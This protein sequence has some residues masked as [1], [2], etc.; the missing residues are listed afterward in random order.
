MKEKLKSYLFH[1][2]IYLKSGKVGGSSCRIVIRVHR[3]RSK[4]FCFFHL[5]H[6]DDISDEGILNLT[7]LLVSVCIPHEID[8]INGITVICLN[9]NTKLINK[10]VNI[11]KNIF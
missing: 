6:L 7:C 5:H 10:Y 2:I 9:L 1:H 8:M 11:E 4:E 3:L